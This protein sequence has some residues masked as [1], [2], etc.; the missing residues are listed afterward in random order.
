MIA[1]RTI[2]AIAGTLALAAV[3]SA[4]EVKQT[5]APAAQPSI[6]PSN[7]TQDMLDR[8]ANDANNGA[9]ARFFSSG[10]D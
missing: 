1:I 4:Q 3:A 8:A 9:F 2:S 6:T 7:V 5:P 10:T